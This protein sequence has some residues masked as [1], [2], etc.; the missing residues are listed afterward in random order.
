MPKKENNNVPMPKGFKEAQW[1][2][3]G[4]YSPE[5]ALENKQAVIGTIVKT[6][7]VRGRGAD[8]MCHLCQLDQPILAMLSKDED[9]IELE[10]G[11][12]LG[13]GERAKLEVLREVTGTDAKVFIYPKGKKDIG[14]GNDMWVFQVGI[15]GKKREKPITMAYFDDKSEDADRT[16]DVPF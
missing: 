6:I 4:W 12:I 10:A 16:D 11:S 3:D 13:I 5:L 7:M 1:D 8:R 9:P 14:G 15:N 2:I